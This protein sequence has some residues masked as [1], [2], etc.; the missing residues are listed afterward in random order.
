[1]F[2]PG[3]GVGIPFAGEY[4]PQHLVLRGTRAAEGLLL[5]FARR[6]AAI[7]AARCSGERD[8]RDRKFLSWEYDIAV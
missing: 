2:S 8:R 7:I 4:L 6:A 3:S 1:M 5:T